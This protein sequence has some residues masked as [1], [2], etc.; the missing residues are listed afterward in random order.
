[1]AGAGVAFSSLLSSESKLV[2]RVSLPFLYCRG[3]MRTV[4]F[5]ARVIPPSLSLPLPSCDNCGE[6]VDGDAMGGGGAGKVASKSAYML[7]IGGVGGLLFLG[8]GLA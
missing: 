6:S 3:N 2:S 4:F 1:L 5:C 7:S 8:S